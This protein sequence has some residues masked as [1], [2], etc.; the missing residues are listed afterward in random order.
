MKAEPLQSVSIP[1]DR[2]RSEASEQA[3]QAC[4]ELLSSGHSVSEIL[5]L[6]QLGPLDKA[7]IRAANAPGERKIFHLAGNGAAPPRWK[8]VQVAEPADV[9]RGL[10]PLNLAPSQP[11][12]RDEEKWP[13]PIGV[14]L[15]WL[16]PAMSLMLTGIAG[17]LLVDARPL[18]GATVSA[19]AV[20]GLPA[21]TQVG[22]TA[23][24]PPQTAR[25]PASQAA[26]SAP[27][28]RGPGIQDRTA[29]K[30]SSPP[31]SRPARRP[32]MEVYRLS[33]REWRIPTRLTDGF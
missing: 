23:P 2:F 22:G 8:I 24:D 20:A 6:K 9:S 18:G 26:A 27:P 13:R 32:Y 30:P 11:R 14:A 31:I 1:I 4:Y 21:I 5:S 15:F 19:E 12:A 10:V 7:A 25:N 28:D 29:V 16:L 33:P 17:K 3:I